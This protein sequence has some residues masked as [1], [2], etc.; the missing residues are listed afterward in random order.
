M[1]SMIKKKKKAEE[2]ILISGKIHF[3]TKKNV[4]QD[5]EGHFINV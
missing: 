5:K 3:K 4:T 2:A 1:P